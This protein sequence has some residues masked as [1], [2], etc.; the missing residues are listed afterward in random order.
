MGEGRREEWGMCSCADEEWQSASGKGM[1]KCK[2][3][4]PIHPVSP[5]FP[6]F[7]A[8][9][10]SGSA[11]Q[12]YS[13]GQEYSALSLFSGTRRLIPGVLNWSGC[14][15]LSLFSGTR[16]LSPGVLTWSGVCGS[17]HVFRLS[18]GVLT[19]SGA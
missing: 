7:Q 1:Y 16:R 3:N 2:D 6:W 14:S 4:S 15:F 13:L 11:Q 8:A 10:F 19:W 5:F 17:F 9:M 18:P 12:V